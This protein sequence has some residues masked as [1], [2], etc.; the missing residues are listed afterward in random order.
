MVQSSGCQEEALG[1]GGDTLADCGVCL[2]HQTENLA[3]P[4]IRKKKMKT[5]GSTDNHKNIFFPMYNP[6][7][8]KRQI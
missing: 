2:T 6:A 3:W 1:T 5:V 4:R 7:V 8:V